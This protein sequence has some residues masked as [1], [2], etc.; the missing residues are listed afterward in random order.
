M[1]RLYKPFLTAVYLLLFAAFTSTSLGQTITLLKSASTVGED[2]GSVTLTAKADIAPA[3]GVTVTVT[4]TAIGT[5]GTASVGDYVLGSTTI[6]IVG[7]G[8][9]TTGTTTLSG[10]PDA[11]FEGN[12]TVIVEITGVS[13]NGAGGGGDQGPYTELGAQ[14]QI[15]QINDAETIS[16]ARDTSPIAEDGGTVTYTATVSDGG[17]VDNVDVTVTMDFTGGTAISTTDFTGAGNITISNGTSSG[18]VLITSSADTFLEGDETIVGTINGLSYGTIGSTPSATTTITDAESLI[19]S[20]GATITEA[21]TATLTATVSDGGTLKLNGGGNLSITL[22]YTGTA[23]YSTDY[24][25]SG[26]ANPEGLT[27]INNTSSIS[28]TITPVNDATIELDETVIAAMTTA[29]TGLTIA[30][31]PQTV[32][33]TDDIETVLSSP[34]GGATDQALNVALSWN[35]VVGADEYKLYVNTASD[36]TGT[37]IING[38]DQGNVLTDTPGGLSDNVPYYWKVVPRNTGSG[39]T[40]AASN[41][42][43]RSFTTIQQSVTG[44]YPADNAVGV[45]LFPTLSW[46]ATNGAD[47]YRLEVNEASNFGG[48]VI[49]D[50]ATLTSTSKQ[51]AGLSNA[52]TYYWRV[53]AS[54]NLLKVN[55]SSV[56][57]FTTSTDKYVTLTYP[58][59]GETVVTLVPTLYWSVTNSVSGLTYEYQINTSNSFT[60]TSPT[61]IVSSATN[62]TTSTLASGQTYYWRARSKTSGGIYSQWSTVGSFVTQAG[63]AA[64]PA[65][66]LSWPVGNPTLFDATPSLYWY[67]SSPA[68]TGATINYTIQV[69]STSGD[70]SSPVFQIFDVTTLNTTVSTTLSAGVTYYWRVRTVNDTAGDSTTS[71]EE[72]FTINIGQGGAPDPVLSWPISNVTVYSNTPTLYWYL[73][74]P[75]TGTPTYDIQ[76]GTVGGSI[77][78]IS[79][80]QVAQDVSATITNQ[81]WTVT[82]SLAPGIYYWQ[83]RTHN[84]TTSNYVLTNGKFTVASSVSTAPVPVVSWPVGGASVYT[85]TPTLYWY[86]GGTAPSGANL[87]FD[88][89]I[90]PATSAYTPNSPTYSNKGSASITNFKV[91]TAL[92]PGDYKWKVRTNNNTATIT[93]DYSSEGTFTVVST[94]SGA[95]VAPTPIY[96]TGNVTVSSLTPTLSWFVNGVVPSLG[97]TYEVELKPTSLAFDEAGL[98]TVSSQSYTSVTLAP[99]TPYHWRVRML[100]ATLTPPTSA[101]SAETFFTTAA[102]LAPPP[103]LVGDPINGVTVPN[104]TP[105]LSWFQP[106]APKT[107]LK[108]KLQISEDQSMNTIDI[109]LD[110]IDAFS[111]V[112]N[113]LKGGTTY[114]WRVQSKDDKGEYSAHSN[115]GRFVTATVTSVDNEPVIPTKFEVEQNY[116]NPFNPTTTI[117]FALPQATFVT[118]K[119]Y[120]MLGQLVKTLINEQKNAGTFNVRWRGDNSS[121]L[122]VSSGTYIYR[123]IAGPN[124]VTKKMI[125]LK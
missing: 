123:V 72:S 69:T 78:N 102:T 56:L 121:G 18:T 51:I 22:T 111:T 66:T 120:N 114:Y 8:S 79:G 41:T 67:L 29:V 76:V 2:A 34:A 57:N 125:L 84:G 6:S 32:T 113:T 55:T 122:K 101:W 43:V 64:A 46:P 40:R 73:S 9:N 109:E 119:I 25:N 82:S 1:N 117:R 108:Y 60:G 17:V 103:P 52:T 86:L 28:T 35:A 63:L 91:T 50:N 48:T 75:A 70:Y 106:T 104:A 27:L 93:S 105:E 15:V 92:T 99:G 33:I 95:G 24:D 96:P 107:T 68:P 19:L 13:D 59:S 94:A 112:V 47:K 62:A 38:V 110:D 20:G 49:Y 87:D 80:S 89:D 36:F 21:G 30:G 90:K 61:P 74:S 31:S 58:K 37:A 83:V 81:Y 11:L 16:I 71:S 23:T 10:V 12:E 116:P 124:I 88:I 115:V 4:I 97:T 98:A 45:E 85:T 26:T 100:N 54:S 3:N 65:A 118:L 7:D 53:T 42:E 5:G 14:F 44:V 39:D 77:A